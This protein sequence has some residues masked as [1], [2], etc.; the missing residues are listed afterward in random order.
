MGRPI[1]D[2]DAQIA[3]IARSRG[4]TLATR[5]T[6]DFE[7]TSIEVVNPWAVKI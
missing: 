6:S 5:N 2:F 1:N 7:G 3:A 4:M